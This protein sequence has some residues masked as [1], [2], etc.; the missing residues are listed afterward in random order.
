M[1]SDDRD[2]G[3]SDAAYD[4]QEQHPVADLVYWE[5]GAHLAGETRHPAAVLTG[6]GIRWKISQRNLIADNIVFRCCAS[7]PAVLPAFIEAKPTSP[8]W[9]SER[10]M[11]MGNW[12]GHWP[13]R[14]TAWQ[15]WSED[16][17]LWIDPR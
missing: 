17:G 7:A 6:L 2:Q 5:I 16:K 15:V 1:V 13:E 9:V 11:R 8:A 4:P 3:M 12:S 10:D 14:P